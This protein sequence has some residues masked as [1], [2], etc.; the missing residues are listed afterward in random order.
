MKSDSEKFAGKINYR[1]KVQ[2]QKGL[3]TISKKLSEQKKMS[4]S[5]SY[6]RASSTQSNILDWVR[7]MKVLWWGYLRPFIIARTDLC[8]TEGASEN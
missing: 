7:K 2:I 3:L 6:I 5:K 4:S 8:V 1:V